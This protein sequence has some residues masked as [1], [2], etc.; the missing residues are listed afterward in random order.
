VDEVFEEEVA[1]LEVTED[2]KADNSIFH[3]LRGNNS[4]LEEL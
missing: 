3:F 1:V 2:T 4:P